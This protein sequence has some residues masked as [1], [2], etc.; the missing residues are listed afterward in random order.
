M[1]SFPV[2]AY[3]AGNALGLG[4]R[5]VLAGLSAGRSGLKPC[6]WDLPFATSCGEVPAP[7]EPLPER[8]S[9][10]DSRVARIAFAVLAELLPAA[11]KAI[12]RWGAGRVA[13]VLGTSTGGILETERAFAAH[14]APATTAR[15][16]TPSPAWS[17]W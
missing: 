2:T 15:G 1:H 17:S 11:S 5:E 14:R 10:Y 4:T 12:T 9:A 16:S 13:V 7:L 3:A 6:G 8:W